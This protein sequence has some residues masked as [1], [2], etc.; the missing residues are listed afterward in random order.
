MD[1]NAQWFHSSWSILLQRV[2]IRVRGFHLVCFLF[3]QEISFFMGLSR[4]FLFPLEFL[5]AND[6][7]DERSNGPKET[8]FL[9]SFFVMGWVCIFQVW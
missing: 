9:P 4:W 5:T 3:D 1:T 6:R 8:D 2:Y 7:H